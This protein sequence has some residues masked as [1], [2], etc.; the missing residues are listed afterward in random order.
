MRKLRKYYI[1]LLLFLMGARLLDK[2]AILS[3]IAERVSYSD[4]LFLIYLICWSIYNLKQPSRPSLIYSRQQKNFFIY[5]F[6][7]SFWTGMSWC[8]TTIFR[9]GYIPDFFGIPVRIAIYGIMALFVAKWVKE[10]G[11]NIF[12]APF[13]IGILTMFYFNFFSSA[14][15]VLRVPESIAEKNFSGVL[16]PTCAIYLSLSFLCRPSF[17][18]L[19]LL[20]LAVISTTLVYSLGGVVL[21]VLFLP[22]A[23]IIVKQY[24]LG[25]GVRF[26]RK[27]VAL[28]LIISVPLILKANSAIQPHLGT[29]TTNVEQKIENAPGI[30]KSHTESGDERFGF[31]LSSIVI[32]YRN[33]IFGVGEADWQE[34][35]DKNQDWL[36]VLYLE[37]DNPH[38]AIAEMISMFGIPSLFLF[39]AAFYF[40]FKELYLLHMLKGVKWKVF[41]ISIFLIF[42]GIANLM[43]AIFTSYFFY[44]FASLVF[45]IRA[46]Q[47]AIVLT[48]REA[49]K[50][51]L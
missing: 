12:V 39:A 8:V 48:D 29:V 22:V 24:F 32:A 46:R 5:L 15:T 19:F 11:P 6:S 50:A 27:L 23:W 28:L 51:G 30:S 4:I 20:L 37:S 13:C 16:L 17:W 33:P 35:N 47:Q 9:K 7:F 14:M 44:F 49:I 36:G 31:F 40:V 3:P 41:V 26:F 43:D 34:E 10:Y 45:G 1:I 18:A 21:A 2:E 42:G 38:N 25:S